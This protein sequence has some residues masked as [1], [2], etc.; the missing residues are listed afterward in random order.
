MNR[1]GLIDFNEI[2]LVLDEFG[3]T[4]TEQQRKNYFKTVKDQNLTIDFEQFLLLMSKSMNL[5]GTLKKQAS[6]FHHIVYRGAQQVKKLRK[7]TV[8]K[9]LMTGIF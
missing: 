7:L 5:D 1:D 4:S 3:D 6:N 8:Y 9:Q 2:C